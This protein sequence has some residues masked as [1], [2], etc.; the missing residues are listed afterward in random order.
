MQTS[1][2]R[3]GLK[4]CLRYD[5]SAKF[6]GGG[7]GAGPFLARSLYVLCLKINITHYKEINAKLY[8]TCTLMT[9]AH[10]TVNQLISLYHTFCEALDAG[11]EVRAVFCDISKTFARV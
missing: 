11:T 10:S 7:W 3:C 2:K 1:L 5:M 6:P 4:F 8:N 9:Q